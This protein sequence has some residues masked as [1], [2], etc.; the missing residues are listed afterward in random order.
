[1]RKHFSRISSNSEAFASELIGEIVPRYYILY[2]VI[3]LTCLIIH[4]CVSCRDRVENT[5]PHMNHTV[6]YKILLKF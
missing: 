6:L 3:C 2:R 5:L 1:M 4:Y